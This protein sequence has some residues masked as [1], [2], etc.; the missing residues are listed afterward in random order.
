MRPRSLADFITSSGPA[1]TYY[2][3]RQL[4]QIPPWTV[5]VAAVEDPFGLLSNLVGKPSTAEKTLKTTFLL[6]YP[7]QVLR[8]YRNNSLRGH[9]AIRGNKSSD[10]PGFSAV[11]IPGSPRRVNQASWFGAQGP[12]LAVG[13]F[14]RPWEGA[15]H[16]F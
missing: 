7:M 11:D 13:S 1:T 4:H 9:R 6:T 3:T 8:R 15:M 14:G 12:Y 16:S 5:A 2:H 10:H